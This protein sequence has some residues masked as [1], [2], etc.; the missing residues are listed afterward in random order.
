MA[1][2]RRRFLVQEFF[3]KNISSQAKI[4]REKGFNPQP[5]FSRRKMVGG[6][7]LVEVVVMIGI[8]SVLTSVVLANYRGFITNAN[9]SNS[10]ENV[11]IALR[12]AQVYGVAT[13]K[14]DVLCGVSTFTCAFGVH[15][16]TS[17][18]NSLIIFVDSNDNKIYE[19][20]ELI[21]T[22]I[23]HLER[24]YNLSV[25]PSQLVPHGSMLRLGV[26]TQTR[27]LQTQHHRRLHI[28]PQVFNLRM[29]LKTQW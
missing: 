25:V 22:R 11:V 13:K 7:T 24:R 5:S 3:M 4:L 6:F 15:F 23:F 9:F 18:L 16:D 21:E 12:E 26:Q 8:F 14:S 20:A 19:V 29:A 1:N 10:S 27:S 17:N 28:I 2:K